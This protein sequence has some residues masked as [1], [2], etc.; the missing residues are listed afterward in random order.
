MKPVTLEDVNNAILGTDIKILSVI[1]ILDLSTL[2]S[3]PLNIFGVYVINLKYKESYIGKS[4]CNRGIQGRLTRHVCETWHRNIV[5]SIDIFVTNDCHASFLERIMIKLFKPELNSTMYDNCSLTQF[6]SIQKCLDINEDFT[7]EKIDYNED[8]INRKYVPVPICDNEYVET[9]YLKKY[10]HNT[11]E[12]DVCEY[13]IYE[14]EYE[15]RYDNDYENKDFILWLKSQKGRNDP[16]GDIALDLTKGLK[17]KTIKN[18]HYDILYEAY[19]E[20]L[21][22]YLNNYKQQ[23]ENFGLI[24]V[25]SLNPNLSEQIN[26]DK[27]FDFNYKILCKKYDEIKTIY[28]KNNYNTWEEKIYNDSKNGN[29][30]G[31]EWYKARRDIRKI[32]TDKQNTIKKNLYNLLLE[33]NNEI[34]NLLKK[35]GKNTSCVKESFYYSLINH[36]LHW[37]SNVNK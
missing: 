12:S 26:N 1:N 27:D 32:W 18:R 33:I 2:N 13:D 37:F 35:Y 7:C 36:D 16:I 17:I 10:E 24:L 8:N 15:N 19:N 31:D 11:Y 21:Y 29:L 3:V 9:P 20:Y 6:M 22:I 14:H 34:E 30:S 4:S 23:T 25:E 28:S 5:E